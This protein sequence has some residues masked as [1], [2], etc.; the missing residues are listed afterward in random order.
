MPSPSQINLSLPF[1]H[2]SPIFPHLGCFPVFPTEKGSGDA[3]ALHGLRALQRPGSALSDATL[4]GEGDLPL[5]SERPG[6]HKSLK[7]LEARAM[8][9]HFC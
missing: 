4:H 1:T 8:V 9:S 2:L 3:A 7:E 6:H 5:G